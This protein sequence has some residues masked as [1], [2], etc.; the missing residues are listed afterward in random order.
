MLVSIALTALV[1]GCSAAPMVVPPAQSRPASS[2]GRQAAAGTFS[3]N[4]AQLAFAGVDSP[5]QS[6]TLA[7]PDM[8]DVDFNVAP[9][10]VVTVGKAAS[11]HDGEAG[12]DGKKR[13]LSVSPAGLGSATIT[14]RHA[15]SVVVTIPVI[16][17]PALTV[18]VS[19]QGT[20][21]C[22]VSPC[23]SSGIQLINATSFTQML[24]FT[25]TISEPNYAGA[26]TVTNTDGNCGVPNGAPN[27]FAATS[28]A[29]Q[30]TVGMAQ[31]AFAGKGTYAVHCSLTVT[32]DHGGSQAVALS[33]IV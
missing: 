17:G 4:P 21:D 6:V 3:A 16:V 1:A 20:I 28:T 24:P 5:A 31:A 8:G 13:V 7:G 10:G 25:L 23:S 33:W 15:N 11:A 19:P 2:E 12:D 29:T 9:A 27:P 30:V 22:T 18:A 32:D 14:V 26:F